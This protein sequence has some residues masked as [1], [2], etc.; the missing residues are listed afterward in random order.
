MYAS[1]SSAPPLQNVNRPRMAPVDDGPET[2]TPG[3]PSE[4]DRSR[5]PAAPDSR[6]VPRTPAGLS[7]FQVS[8]RSDLLQLSP[9]LMQRRTPV[10]LFA[11]T[12]MT[13]LVG[14]AGHSAAATSASKRVR[15]AIRDRAGIG[16]METPSNP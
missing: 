1:R 12:E 6:C 13:P 9:S 15:R 7:T 11:H 5:D 4:P 3:A 8:N 2:G 16:R 10:R 14:S